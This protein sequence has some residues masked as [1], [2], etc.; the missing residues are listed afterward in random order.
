[1]DKC[2]EYCMTWDEIL[3]ETRRLITLG[4]KKK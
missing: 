2:N 1:M 4:E 3:E